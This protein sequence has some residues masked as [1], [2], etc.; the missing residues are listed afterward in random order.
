M[1]VKS[2]SAANFPISPRPFFRAVFSAIWMVMAV[3]PG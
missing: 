2:W 3:Q 1:A